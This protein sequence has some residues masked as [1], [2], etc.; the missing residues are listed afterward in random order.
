MFS[1]L[2]KGRDSFLNPFKVITKWVFFGHTISAATVT[3]VWA[4]AFCTQVDVPLPSTGAWSN[5]PRWDG[6]AHGPHFVHFLWIKSRTWQTLLPWWLFGTRLQFVQFHLFIV[7]PLI[8]KL[9]LQGRYS[10]CSE[11]LWNALLNESNLHSLDFQIHSFLPLLSNKG[12][13]HI[14]TF[15]LR[16]PLYPTP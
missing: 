10:V 7:F 16:S 6:P 13:L 15:P 4:M 12:T 3:Q 2:F 11:Y 5:S 9:A 8:S 14:M 1:V